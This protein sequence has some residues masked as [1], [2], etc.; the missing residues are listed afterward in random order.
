MLDGVNEDP[1]RAALPPAVNLR[2]ANRNNNTPT[3]RTVRSAACCTQYSEVNEHG[4]AARSK[5]QQQP[6]CTESSL[7]DA[8]HIGQRARRSR[9][10]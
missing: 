7:L 10:Q 3:N 8:V 9:A 5:P 1:R 4:E 2:A 6:E